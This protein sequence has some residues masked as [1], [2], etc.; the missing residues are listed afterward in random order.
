MMTCACVVVVS[1]FLEVN[2][3]ALPLN[4][5]F[6]GPRGRSRGKKIELGLGFNL[7]LIHTLVLFSLVIVLI[8]E[9][10]R[11]KSLLNISCL[12]V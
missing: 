12:L 11:L 1:H 8:Y 6:K 9:N 10:E 7:F 3:K 5:L 4:T 2:F